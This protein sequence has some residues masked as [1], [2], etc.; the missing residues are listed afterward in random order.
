MPLALSQHVS[1]ILPSTETALE[2]LK[3]LYVQEVSFTRAA[4]VRL[5]GPGP[6]V[7]DLLQDVFLVAHRRWPEL[8]QR[9]EPRGWLYGVCVRVVAAKRRREKL[10]RTFGLETVA[11]P[12]SHGTPASAL[13]RTEATRRLYALLD[14]LPEKQRA[15]FVLFELE[16]CSGEQIAE[17]VG[18]PLQTVWTRLF[19]ARK[20]LTRLADKQRLREQRELGEAP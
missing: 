5:R 11:E 20:N 8:R 1:Q 19:H 15:V 2:S 17:A 18:C 10:R 13:D 14:K 9:A 6:D 4:L 12:A 7:E 16:G 3:A